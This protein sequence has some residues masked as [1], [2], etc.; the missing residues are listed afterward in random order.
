VRFSIQFFSSLSFAFSLALFS[1]GAEPESPSEPEVAVEEPVDAP[2][3]GVGTSEVGDLPV[4]GVSTNIPSDVVSTNEVVAIPTFDEL[5]AEYYIFVE[6]TMEERFPMFENDIL[7]ELLKPNGIQE[8]GVIKSISE[9][10][11]LMVQS[12]VERLIP[13]RELS[14]FDRLKTDEDFRLLWIREQT[15]TYVRMELNNPDVIEDEPSLE[16]ED[17]ILKALVKGDPAAQLLVGHQTLRRARRTGDYSRTF[18]YYMLATTQG[19]TEAKFNLGVMYYKGYGVPVNRRKGLQLISIASAE[20]YKTA[21]VFLEQA[22][23]NVEEAQRV[24]QEFR[25]KQ[26]AEE[27]AFFARRAKVEKRTARPKVQKY[28]KRW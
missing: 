16:Y 28:I 1:W 20:G 6:D 27:K 2:V 22:R 25:E 12:G 13:H 15:R 21:E 5:E 3:V 23:V 14:V 18:L 8:K 10:G 11:L 4:D 7:V 19:N 24:A 9:D 17:E 26:D